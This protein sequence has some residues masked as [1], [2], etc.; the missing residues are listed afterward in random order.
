MGAGG[1]PPSSDFGEP[2]LPVVM[3]KWNDG[4]GESPAAP[5]LG[6]PAS[7]GQAG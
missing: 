4:G 3:C 7:G 5:A 2:L 1:L 6:A